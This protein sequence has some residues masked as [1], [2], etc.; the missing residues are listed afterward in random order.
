M[1][2]RR[3][4]LNQ[5][6]IIALS[7]AAQSQVIKGERFGAAHSLGVYYAIGTEVRTDTLIAEAQKLGKKVSLPV[8]QGKIITFHEY[9]SSSSLVKGKYGIME[10]KTHGKP[11][12]LDLLIV[13]G[14]AFDRSGFRLGYGK[15]YYDRYLAKEPTYSIGLAYSFQIIDRIPRVGHDR[16]LDAVATENGFIDF[17]A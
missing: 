12:H 11:A 8:V 10:P 4:V 2:S 1:L 14:I 9:S 3:N 7:K 17:A 15:G 5:A 16:N 6:E 13:P